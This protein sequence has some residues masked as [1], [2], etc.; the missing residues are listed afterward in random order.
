MRYR[1]TRPGPEAREFVDRYWILEVDGGGAG[2]VQR[3]MP[4]GSPELILNFEQPFES[5]QEGAWRPQPR[6]FLAGQITGPLL[7]RAAGKARIFGVRFTPSGAGRLLGS[8]IEQ[9][10]NSA[11]PLDDLSPGLAN[12]LDMPLQASE[13]E[14]VLLRHHRTRGCSDPSIDLAAGLLGGGVDV[15]SAAAQLGLSVRQL[16]RRF[17]S[18]VG[19]PPHLFLRLRRFQRVFQAIDRRDPRWADTAVACGYYDQAHL[20]RDFRQFSGETPS[21]LLANDELARH[22][23]RVSGQQ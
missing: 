1:E 2:E 4:D 9:T 21:A 15:A 8:I 10:T 11:V 13:I 5:L 18:M 23:L 12:A 7:L 6:N 14:A 20:I 16:E 3:V 17:R 19:L 22:F